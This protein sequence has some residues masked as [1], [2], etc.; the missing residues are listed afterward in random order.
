MKRLWFAFLNSLD[1]LVA[2]WR[3]EAAFRQEAIAAIFLIPLALFIAPDAVSMALMMGSIFM[4]L[5]VELINTAVESAIDRIG[6][7][8]DDL[9]KKAKDTA[10]AAV[11]VALTNAVIVWIVV[12]I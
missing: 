2:A 7:H 12:L 11:L 4:V 9:A 3:G 8:R 5:M 10:S 6:L 1:G